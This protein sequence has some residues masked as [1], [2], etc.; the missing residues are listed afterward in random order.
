MTKFNEQLW[1]EALKQP[2]WYLRLEADFKRLEAIAAAQPR[3][4]GQK[5][6]KDDAYRLVEQALQAGTLPLASS[7]EDIDKQRLPIDTLVI[8]HTKNPP[9]MSLERLNAMQLLRIYGMYYANPTDR[10]ETHFKGMP[11]WSNHFYKKQPVFWVYHW[12]IRA[13]GKLEH[14]LDDKYIG[15]NS[16]NWEVNKKSVAICV[17]DNLSDKEPGGVVIR[18]IANLIKQNYSFINHENILGHCDINL[19]TQCPGVLFHQSWREK[20]LQELV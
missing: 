4:S 10:L 5:S 9:G 18:A 3:A 12:L 20:I 6:V 7:G 17:D 11:I 14:I 1:R 19:Q 2:D 13:N 16:G 8:H 15:W